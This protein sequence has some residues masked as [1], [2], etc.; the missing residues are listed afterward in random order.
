MAADR[1]ASTQRRHRTLYGRRKGH[2][3]RAGQQARLDAALATFGI[4]LPLP[5]CLDPAAMFVPPAE[6]TWIEIGFGGGEHLAHMAA[7][8]PERGFIGC[9]PYLNGVA[10]LAKA[11]EDPGLNNIR[12]FMGDGLELLDAL[13]AAS[14]AGL[15][16]LFPDPWPKT[17][18]H[19]RRFIQPQALDALARILRDGAAA[20][21]RL[22][23]IRH[24]R[25]RIYRFVFITKPDQTRDMDGA[26][27]R[28]AFSFRPLSPR[29]QR[30][31]RARRITLRAV[32]AGDNVET[33][34]RTMTV[35]EAPH[36]WFRVLNGLGPDDRLRVGQLVK[37]VSE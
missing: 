28:T 9:E 37:V 11:I 26:S 6:A 5:G 29:E 24:S 4:S 15:F 19:K 32:K 14:I 27:R 17:R 21:V 22:V 20:D 1:P 8:H 7:A 35:D 18:H 33:F 23:A 31:L 10:S 3:L 2:R 25:D 36:R 30:Q 34:A 16:L 12:L 13:P